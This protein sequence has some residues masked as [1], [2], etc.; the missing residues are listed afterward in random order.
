MRG[1]GRPPSSALESRTCS[2]AVRSRLASD[3]SPRPPPRQPLG[4]EPQVLGRVFHPTGAMA[5]LLDIGRQGGTGIEIDL[6][7]RP[8]HLT[9]QLLVDGFL[10]GPQERIKRGV[11]R[12]FRLLRLARG[13]KRLGGFLDPLRLFRRKQ[14]RSASRA[15]GSPRSRSRCGVPTRASWEAGS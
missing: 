12:P 8:T 6:L 9:E 3:S 13:E 1:C 5:V 4:I 15:P 14:A 10:M 7:P 2:P 11:E